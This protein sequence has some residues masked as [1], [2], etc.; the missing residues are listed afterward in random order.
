MD[1]KYIEGVRAALDQMAQTD[2]A[3]KYPHMMYDPK[4]GKEV[5]AKTPADHDKF[6]KMGYTHEKPKMDEALDDKDKSTMMKVAK[7]LKKAS[8]AHAG[9]SD[10]IMKDI[11]DQK[12][13]IPEDIPQNERTA[14][15]GAA[16]AAAKAGKKSFNFG[17]KTHPV[18][19]KKD[20]ATK[21]ADQKESVGRTPG[22]KSYYHLQRAKA[23]AK[24]DGH[25][26]DKLPKYDRAKPHQDQYHDMAK[27]ESV[28]K[29]STMTIKDKLI[30]V[31]EGDKAAHYKGATAPEPMIKDD[32]RGDKKMK[33]GHP[34]KK[35]EQEETSTAAEKSTKA[36]PM[37]G[38]DNKQGDKNIIPS[39]T[40][41][42]PANKVKKEEYG[43]FGKKVSNSLLKAY[44]VVQEFTHEFDVDSKKN[45]N[46]MVKKA[47]EAGMKAKIHTMSGPGGGNPVVHIGHKDTGEIHKLIKK[48]YDSSYKKSDL[49]M[50]KL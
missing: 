6:A 12:Y 39:A 25:D 3:V 43:V 26:F 35:A 4:T 30:A 19:M 16:A 46:F 36:S 34:I 1:R 11:K 49:D 7:K 42:T 9:Q 40:K 33:D 24:K 32:A 31:L 20:V 8:A 13:H 21:I 23:L 18:T 48:H 14:F 37:R 45:A 27:K 5:T 41:D 50:H 44:S 15:H 22:D 47:K 17:G 38:N 10:A 2:E 29:E 28:K